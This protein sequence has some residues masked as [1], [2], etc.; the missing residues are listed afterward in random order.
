MQTT[1][2]LT[3]FLLPGILVAYWVVSDWLKER[4]IRREWAGQPL[5][6]NAIRRP[7]RG[8]VVRTSVAG[9]KPG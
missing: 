2:L 8:S 5:L 3:A 4:A 9:R 6:S 1:M 7:R